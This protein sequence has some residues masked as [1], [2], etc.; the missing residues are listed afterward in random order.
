MRACAWLFDLLAG[1]KQK[2]AEPRYALALPV[3]TGFIG[4]GACLTGSL[5]ASSRIPSKS[6][7][8]L[9][10]VRLREPQQALADW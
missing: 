10:G 8:I 6:R 5:P 1:A 4:E 2:V 3:M 9:R 7:S